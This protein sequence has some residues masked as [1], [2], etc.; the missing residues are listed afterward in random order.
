MT[1][2]NAIDKMSKLYSI[3]VDSATTANEKTTAYSKLK[4]F[5]HKN[6]VNLTEFIE[7]ADFDRNFNARASKAADKAKE[8]REAAEAKEYKATAKRPSRRSLIVEMLKTNLYD[9]ASINEV[10]SEVF[11]YNDLKANKKAISGT[12]YDFR[13]NKGWFFRLCDCGRIVTE[14]A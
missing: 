8:R 5:A 14:V 2:S 10:L 7:N 13:V 3:Y 9:A 1:R 12:Q 6:K 4:V 11:S